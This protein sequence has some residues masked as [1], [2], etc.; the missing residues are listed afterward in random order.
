MDSKEYM[1]RELIHA[2]SLQVVSEKTK[3]EE[4]RCFQVPGLGQK[5]F[6][7]LKITPWIWQPFQWKPGL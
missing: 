1:D 3:K 5:L 7:L 4:K 6:I 2:C